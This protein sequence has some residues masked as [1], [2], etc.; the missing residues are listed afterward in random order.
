MRNSLRGFPIPV[1]A[2]AILPV[3]TVLPFIPERAGFVAARVDE[4]EI[5]LVRHLIPLDG[6]RGDVNRVSF[7]LVVP[8]KRIALARK[9][10]CDRACGDLDAAVIRGRSDS[11]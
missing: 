6:K 2:I 8:A 3:V 10:E 7:I 4:F 9:S 5:L 1:F 11:G